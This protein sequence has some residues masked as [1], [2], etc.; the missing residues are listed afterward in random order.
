MAEVILRPRPYDQNKACPFP[1]CFLTVKRFQHH[2]LAEALVVCKAGAVVVS[3]KPS[4]SA[5]PVASPQWEVCTHT[6]P[7][8]HETLTACVCDKDK[9]S[10]SKLEKSG[11]RA[12]E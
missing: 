2:R 5:Y 9:Y 4:L 6:P 10:G 7:R 12:V 11:C 3:Q 8:A 1:C